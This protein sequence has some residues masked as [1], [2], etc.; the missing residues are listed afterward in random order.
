MKRI[1]SVAIGVL[2]STAIGGGL[3]SESQAQAAYKQD[4]LTTQQDTSAKPQ[5]NQNRRTPRPTPRPP[6]R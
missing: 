2:L 6:R 5:T 4:L 1:A 3:L